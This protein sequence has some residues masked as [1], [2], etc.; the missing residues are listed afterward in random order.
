MERA[1]IRDLWRSGA[2]L[3]KVFT[4]FGEIN[5]PPSLPPWPSSLVGRR[6]EAHLNDVGGVVGRARQGPLMCVTLPKPR[7]RLNPQKS[8][9]QH[10][11]E[12]FT[13]R[14]FVSPCGTPPLPRW[15]ASLPHGNKASRRRRLTVEDFAVM[16]QLPESYYV[17]RRASRIRAAPN[18]VDY[19]AAFHELCN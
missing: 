16:R 18:R 9:C 17:Q 7:K 1:F 15:G 11:D 8:I 6:I 3:S 10:N 12:L 4:Y 14:T 2:P 13:W 19:G 5:S